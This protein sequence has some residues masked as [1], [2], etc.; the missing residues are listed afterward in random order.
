M[1]A[2]MEKEYKIQYEA[3][4]VALETKDICDVE[5]ALYKPLVDMTR[6]RATDIY[7]K[8]LVLYESLRQEEKMDKYT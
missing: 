7:K 3:L 6:I 1:R 8:V 5:R 2:N 4:E